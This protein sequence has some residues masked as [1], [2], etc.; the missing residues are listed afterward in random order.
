MMVWA[1]K[2]HGSTDI[3]RVG[4]GRRPEVTFLELA[5]YDIKMRA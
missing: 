4:D 5:R 2:T 3:G 1:A